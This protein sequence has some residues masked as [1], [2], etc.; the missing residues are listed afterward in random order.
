VTAIQTLLLSLAGFDDARLTLVTLGFRFWLTAE[1]QVPHDTRE[2][3]ASCNCGGIPLGHTSV[4]R[5][6]ARG[7]S[8]LASGRGVAGAPTTAAAGTGGGA[9]IDFRHPGDGGSAAAKEY[10]WLNS[11][12]PLVSAAWLHPVDS[13]GAAVPITPLNCFDNTLAT[14]AVG[15]SLGGSIARNSSAKRWA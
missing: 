12:S 11:A 15:L 6:D 8:F 4:P 1:T 10:G 7:A 14:Q 9:G 13:R 5:C 2:K 3:A